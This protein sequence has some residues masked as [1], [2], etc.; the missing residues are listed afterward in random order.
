RDR[1][2]TG[3]QTCALPIW[4]GLDQLV[5]DAVELDDVLLL[6]RDLLQVLD[7]ARVGADLV[8]EDLDARADV[9]GRQ[10]AAQIDR[11]VAGDPGR[12]R[13]EERRVGKG[14]GQAGG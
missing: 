2:V 13:S 9:G 11:G 5:V 4:L 7:V 14:R 1:T 8:M 3:V 6:A 12:A 10:R